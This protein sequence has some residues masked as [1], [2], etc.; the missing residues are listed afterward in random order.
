MVVSFHL[1][2]PA[3]LPPGNSPLYAFDWELGGPQS[4]SG[5]GRIVPPRTARSLVTKLTELPRLQLRM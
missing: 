1:H 3:T 5:R 2:S 4:R